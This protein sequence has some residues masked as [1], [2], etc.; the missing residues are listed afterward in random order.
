MA[1]SLLREHLFS[2][3]SLVE[4]ELQKLNLEQFIK[5]LAKEIIELDVDDDINLE[6]SVEMI[7]NMDLNSI[8]KLVN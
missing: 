7:D 1:E 8:F 4:I 5:Q 3:Y 6:K 2:K